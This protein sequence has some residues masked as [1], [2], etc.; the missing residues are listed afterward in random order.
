MKY[1]ID[2]IFDKNGAYDREGILALYPEINSNLHK[3]FVLVDKNGAIY[4]DENGK[5]PVYVS[6][7][8]DRMSR[9]I[10]NDVQ[11]FFMKYA[12]ENGI[13]LK[14]DKEFSIFERDVE[15]GTRWDGINALQIY[16]VKKEFNSV[17]EKAKKDFT[18]LSEM[19]NKLDIGSKNTRHSLYVEILLNAIQDRDVY[20]SFEVEKD[21]KKSNSRSFVIKTERDYELDN[22]RE[23]FEL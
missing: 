9:H 11:A 19:L 7:I 3:I 6:N 18:D 13:V 17:I 12:K 5:T 14:M 1:G 20:T 10:T 4:K 15:Y 22:E 16:S 2:V 8:N 23:D 21:C